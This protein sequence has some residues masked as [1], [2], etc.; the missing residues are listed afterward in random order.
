MAEGRFKLL[1]T[2]WALWISGFVSVLLVRR[3]LDYNSIVPICSRRGLDANR[4]MI[5]RVRERTLLI[6][7]GAGGIQRRSDAGHNAFYRLKEK[8]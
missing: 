4:A 2:E 5:Y 1:R 3:A 7:C 6:G 8:K